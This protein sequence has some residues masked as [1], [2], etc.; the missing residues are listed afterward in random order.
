MYV[1]LSTCLYT[2]IRMPTFP[3]LSPEVHMCMVSYYGAFQESSLPGILTG[4][5]YLDI[6]APH[7]SLYEPLKYYIHTS[8]C[9]V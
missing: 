9:V 1:H 8:V 3:E 4:K 2:Y 5:P 6:C 7:S